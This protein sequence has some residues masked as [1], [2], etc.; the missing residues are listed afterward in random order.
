MQECQL[1][2]LL[3]SQFWEPNNYHHMYHLAIAQKIDVACLDT[4]DLPSI[5][6]FFEN[7]PDHKKGEFAWH[8]AQD[9][10]FN[11]NDDLK[12]TKQLSRMM[13]GAL[14]ACPARRVQAFFTSWT[15]Q[16][17]RYNQSGAPIK[18]RLRCDVDFDKLYFENLAKGM[19]YNPFDAIALA[20]YAKGDDFYKQNEQL[21]HHLRKAEEEILNLAKQL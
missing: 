13:W 16:E 18:W 10:R 5:Y 3:I 20:I 1:G 19:A 7:L 8:L 2:R 17:G 6:T 9:L 12:S 14:M 21:V 15:G 11:Y 4:H